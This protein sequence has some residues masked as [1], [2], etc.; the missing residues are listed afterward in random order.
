MNQKKVSML[1]AVLAIAAISG[2][3]NARL[4]KLHLVDNTGSMSLPYD[5]TQIRLD[6]AKQRSTDMIGA[7]IGQKELN[8]VFLLQGDDTKF[9]GNPVDGTSN[10]D[11]PGFQTPAQV[12]AATGSIK[13]TIRNL[14]PTDNYSVFTPLAAAICQ[15]MDIL[16][17]MDQKYNTEDNTLSLYIYTDGNENDTVNTIC[18][19]DVEENDRDFVANAVKVA[20]YQTNQY[21]IK[22]QAGVPDRPW[23]MPGTA[24]LVTGKEANQTTDMARAYINQDGAS[25]HADWAGGVQP[26]SWQWKTYY[27]MFWGTTWAQDSD[28]PP[29]GSM[30]YE[31]WVNNAVWENIP[32][33]GAPGVIVNIESVYD[34]VTS[35]P[36]PLARTA[37]EAKYIE[38][39]S[40]GMYPVVIDKATSAISKKT[41]K[42][43][44]RSATAASSSLSSTEDSFFAGVTTLSTGRYTRIPSNAPIPQLGDMDGD[45]DVDEADLRIVLSWFGRSVDYYNQPSI[46]SDLMTDGFITNLDVNV[47]RS[48]WSV[49]TKDAPY[50]G[51]LDYNWCVSQSDLN[52]VMQWL[53][54]TVSP[55]SQQSYHA[56]INGDGT[57][58]ADD[59]ALV[60]ANMNRGCVP[61]ADGWKGAG[62]TDIDCG[63]NTCGKCST[64]KT[65]SVSADCLSNNCLDHVCQAPAPSNLTATVVVT[66]SWNT[67]YCANL[68]IKNNN[69]VATKN[70]SLVIN[71][72]GG[73][74]SSKWGGTFTGTT[75]N[76]TV[77]PLSYNK[78]IAAGQ[79]ITSAGFCANKGTG[80]TASVTSATGTY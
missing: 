58:N 19:G 40:S 2:T 65:C 12:T 50:I 31:E 17:M 71:L 48:N 14:V 54:R 75:A 36:A 57:I 11:G 60:N 49:T 76:T 45:L 46:N 37:Q 80:G 34:I 10:G 79:K 77:T 61:C 59:V 41:T 25:F 74:F 42:A 7:P 16:A 29:D 47:I 73:T 23:A 6:V 9:L 35:S 44:A 38:G 39:D 28:N 43:V 20:E 18:L 27:R 55:N 51:D 52:L 64:G 72:N 21:V 26:K 68:E 70:W 33:T 78:V 53:G 5:A 24:L 63:G 32:T 15:A 22:T 69:T 67:G 3:A 62:E 13:D 8:G 4:I 66:N 56:D 30:D 1:C